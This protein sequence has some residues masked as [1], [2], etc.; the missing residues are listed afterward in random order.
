MLPLGLRRR[1]TD[2]RGCRKV[3]VWLTL[4]GVSWMSVGIVLYGGFRIIAGW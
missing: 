2:P 3:A 1:W 4:I